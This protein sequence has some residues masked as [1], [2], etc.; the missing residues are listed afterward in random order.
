M[1]KEEVLVLIQYRSLSDGYIVVADNPFT[2][3]L[4][5]IQE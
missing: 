2:V 1:E 5:Y 3:Q 4:N